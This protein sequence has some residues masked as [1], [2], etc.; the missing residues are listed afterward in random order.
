M[1][2]KDNSKSGGGGAFLVLPLQKIGRLSPDVPLVSTLQNEKA[3]NI[4]R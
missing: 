2:Y 3:L 1:T 4:E